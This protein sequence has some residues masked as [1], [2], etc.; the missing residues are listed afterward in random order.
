[1]PQFPRAGFMTRPTPLERL[2]RL[3]DHLKIDL[4]I[5]RDDLAGVTFGGNKTRQLDYYFGQALAEGAD[6][7]LI[8]GAV[9]SNFTR[10]AAAFAAK[11]GMKAFVQL[12]SRVT[13]PT[14]N[15][16]ESGNVMLSQILGAE[17]VHFPVGNDEDGADQALYER[18]EALR[19][20]GAKPY[21]IPLGKTDHPIA[22][23]G[24]QDAAREIMAEDDGFD[25]VVT[26]TGSGMTH[27][28]LIAGFAGTSTHVIGS[29]VRRKAALQQPR[30]R[31][32]LRAFQ[33]M[34]GEA[35][36]LTPDAV[37]IWDGGLW[38]AYGS[39]GPKAKAAM[40]LMARYEGLILDPVYTAKS[41]SAVPEL[42]KEGVIPQGA[43]V[44][45][46]HTGGLGA[47]FAYQEQIMAM[48]TKAQAAEE[49]AAEAKAAKAA[50]A[51]AKKAKAAKKEA[52]KAKKDG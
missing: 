20:E 15:Y 19:A 9:Q 26:G 6:T 50:K 34:T 2:N 31:T 7:I 4:W 18:A 29:C 33:T 5:K 36:P 32:M 46:V 12:E 38:P 35:L 11:L 14:V 43:R 49:D 8:T 10:L 45:Y 24:Y 3:S 27:T 30:I 40:Q 44:C 51:E 25:L 37:D 16:L 52:A 21:V 1:M 23:L 17:V 47:F 13:N 28:G 48:I 22:A 41:F 42:V 39:M